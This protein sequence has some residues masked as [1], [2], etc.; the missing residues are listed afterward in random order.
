M[1][2]T[3]CALVAA[4]ASVMVTAPL[5]AQG[6][7]IVSGRV[8]DSASQQPLVSATIRVV[9]TTSGTLTRNDG[10]YTLS[11]LRPGAQTLRVTRIG[12]AAQTRPVTVAAGASVTADFILVSQAAVLS[13]VV[14]TGYG[15][16]LSATA[17]L[18]GLA[19]DELRPHE[20]NACDPQYPVIVAA[21]A[22]KS[23]GDA[24]TR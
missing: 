12:F 23:V 17:F 22:V 21:R 13:D 15:N 3:R 1:A 10:T 4:L 6:T 9:G 11:G 16:V 8:I 20:L 5:A 24:T 18:Y 14:V 7:G 2:L 19:E